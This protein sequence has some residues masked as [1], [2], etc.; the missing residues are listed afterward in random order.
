MDSVNYER[1]I[2]YN[3]A[4]D[5]AL[6]QAMQ[7]DRNIFVM[8]CG[9]D[10]EGG[11]FGT[12]R[13]AFKTFGPERVIDVPLSENA[14]AGIGVGAAILGKRPVIVH[15]RNDFLMLAMDQ[16]VNHAAKWQFMS[17]GKLHCPLVIRAI[18]GRGWGQGAQHSQS[19]QATFA[20]IPGLKVALPAT[21]YDAKGMLLA[22]FKDKS[23]VIFIEHRLLY[24]TPSIVPFQMYEVPLGQGVIR[25][26]GY[27][28]S[29]VA[30][31][32]MVKEVLEAAEILSQ[33]GIEIEVIDP[34]CAT[35]LDIDLILDSIRKTG[36]AIVADTGWKQFGVSAEVSARIS[37]E[38]FSYLK[39]PVTRIALPDYPTPCG[40]SLEKKF[41]PG[42]KKIVQTVLKLLG[43]PESS[44]LESDSPSEEHAKF[45]GPF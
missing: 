33:Q 19:F 29:I 5:E 35:P 30:F 34:R 6:T 10:D 16:I 13:G 20:H 31:S 11:V 24:Q 21:A 8:G 3:E 44:H 4:L 37:E 7:A 1:Q 40:E 43:S 17:G 18:V 36:R 2:K 15:A 28:L 14:I 38:A 41:Y 9:V 27:D 23:P 45:K 25:R 42:V 22:S 26:K 39:A 12:T 32:Y